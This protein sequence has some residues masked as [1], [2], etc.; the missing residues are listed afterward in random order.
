[1]N[2][3]SKRLNADQVLLRRAR[4]SERY[5]QHGETLA[6]IARDENVSPQQIHKDLKWCREQWRTQAAAAIEEH[7][8]QELAR[9][10]Q[11]E[12][13][14]WQ[15]WRRSIG[16]YI[17]LTTK[18]TSVMTAGNDGGPVELPGIE[19]TKK[20]EKLAGDPR[21]LEIITDCVRQRREILGLDPPKQLTGAGGG[22][23]VLQFAAVPAPPWASHGQG[24]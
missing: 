7:R 22:P 19:E 8:A 24:K 17:T 18:T 6:A 3:F 23:L 20:K 21:F 13:E 2:K 1:M 15:A 4:V 11:V 12:V 10:D 5:C 14:A 9:I 16:I